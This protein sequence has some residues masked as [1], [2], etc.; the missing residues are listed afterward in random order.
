MHRACHTAS[1]ARS[2]GGQVR[3]PYKAYPWLWRGR[4]RAVERK[5]AGQAVT[6]VNLLRNAACFFCLPTPYHK[7]TIRPYIANF[8]ITD[9]HGDG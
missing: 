9:G 3:S 7:V 4:E 8:V 6:E 2:G 1:A 5:R